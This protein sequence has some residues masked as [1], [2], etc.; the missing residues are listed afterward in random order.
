MTKFEQIGSQLQMDCATLFQAE[1]KFRYS[2]K[3]CCNHGMRI[4]CDNCAIMATHEQV[5]AAIEQIAIDNSE[6]K[7]DETACS[8]CEKELA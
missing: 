6:I 2:C 8:K 1:Q 7:N 5:V 4:V 3:I